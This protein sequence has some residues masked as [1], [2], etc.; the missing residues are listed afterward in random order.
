VSDRPR[1]TVLDF[2]MGNLR[3]VAKALEHAGAIV[4]VSPHVDADADGLVVPGQGAF[5]SCVVN[6]GARLDEIRAWIEGG[7][8]YF[9]ICLG[10]QVLFEGSDEEPGARGTGV[11]AG[12]VRRLPDGVKLPHIGWNDVVPSGSSG[13]LTG[14]AQGTRFY[15]VHSYA[16]EPDDASVVAATTHYGDTFCCAVAAGNVWATQFHPEK[17]AGAGL[18]VLGTVVARCAR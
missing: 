2:G 1:L 15:F 18:A 4:D 9:G 13:P 7:R 10:L 16:P 5:G 8:P 14:V 11:L 6:L 17:S 12:A 3:S